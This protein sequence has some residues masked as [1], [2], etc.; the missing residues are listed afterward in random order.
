MATH[1]KQ[2][3]A[4]SAEQLRFR[5][6][7]WQGLGQRPRRLSS[8]YFYDARG[9]ELFERICDTPEYYVTRAE[10]SLIEE[11]AA[12]IAEALGPEVR[13][14]EFG[15]GSGVKTRLLLQALRSPCAYVP[16]DIS[17]TALAESS[18]ALA[19]EFPTLPISPLCA[20]FT[21]PLTLPKLT[22]EARRTVIQLAGSTLGNFTE[23]ESITLLQQMRRAAGAGGAVLLGLDLKKDVARLEAAYNDAEGVTAAFT[24]N[25]LARI[26][27]ELDGDFNL[28]A[29]AH[30]AKYSA[31]AGRIETDIVSQREQHAH[32]AGR[33]FDF[34]AGEAI[35]VEVSTKYNADDIARLAAASGLKP[36]ARW[37]DADG[38]F[39]VVLLVPA[40]A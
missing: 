28:D 16:V 38:D 25:L 17:E 15:N 39:A 26:N 12:S 19:S 1:L 9:S 37:T 18:A 2:P 14:V 4:P 13:L 29:F 27:R 3:L 21:A 24:L 31:E 10:L 22:R 40:L 23:S 30:R 34:G 7:V 6:D 36:Q 8:K 32:V 20:D 11:H 35:R 33:R 5:D